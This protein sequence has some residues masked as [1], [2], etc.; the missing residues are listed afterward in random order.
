MEEDLSLLTDEEIEK[1][2]EALRDRRAQARQNRIAASADKEKA[3]RV[4]KG[5][6]EIGGEAGNILDDILGDLT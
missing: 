1:Q 4:K 2:I 5:P 3:P 6:E